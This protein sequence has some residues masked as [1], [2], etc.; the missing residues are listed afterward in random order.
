MPPVDVPPA[1]IM[2]SEQ[3]GLP[4]DWGQ[5]PLEKQGAFENEVC[6]LSEFSPHTDINPGDLPEG[7]SIIRG[8]SD[9]TLRFFVELDKTEGA[10]KITTPIKNILNKGDLIHL[11][12]GL[13]VYVESEVP[14]V[15]NSFTYD[16]VVTNPVGRDGD[17]VEVYRYTVGVADLS[18][19]E[20]GS[21]V[22]TLRI[23]DSVLSQL[24][25]LAKN[26][27]LQIDFE[28]TFTPGL[29]NGSVVSTR[30]TINP[31][32]TRGTLTFLPGVS[33]NSSVST[34]FTTVEN[35][36]LPPF[37]TTS[38]PYA[39]RY[40]LDASGRLH[41]ERIFEDSKG[42]SFYICAPVITL[43]DPN[44]ESTVTGSVDYEEVEIASNL[45]ALV[46]YDSSYGR[47]GRRVQ[48]SKDVTQAFRNGIFNDLNDI[49]GTL[50][51]G[52]TS[53]SAETYGVSPHLMLLA[54]DG[55]GVAIGGV[56]YSTSSGVDGEVVLEE[57]FFG[58]GTLQQLIE[59]SDR[60]DVTIKYTVGFSAPGT[61]ADTTLAQYLSGS[62]SACLL[63]P[64]ED[65]QHAY[66]PAIQGQTSS[67][68]SATSSTKKDR[69]EFINDQL[70]AAFARSGID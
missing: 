3:A 52:Y 56:S 33:A 18:T 41:V 34:R 58:I 55:S 57:Y 1:N 8:G 13:D 17:S 60:D 43:P 36:D 69:K 39:E 35:Q 22:A 12:I 48:L 42:E 64:E 19:F 27:V 23:P 4:A 32:I 37:N 40:S 53:E 10:G 31:C 51:H 24:R 38:K 7:G 61:G 66:L 6:I 5:D 62:L 21:T 30:A 45:W 16:I 9:N 47:S 63:V 29:H 68:S 15:G 54:Y 2:T 25:D 28:T 20:P 50:I 44:G 46:I 65:V 11:D 59:L 70:K 67:T 26:S 49:K 14:A